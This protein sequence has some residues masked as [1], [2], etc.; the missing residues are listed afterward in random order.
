MGDG[1][2]FGAAGRPPETATRPRLLLRATEAIADSVDFGD[3]LDQ[4]A[5]LAVTEIADIC[6]IDAIHD[7]RIVRLAAVHRDPAHQSLVDELLDKYPPV[8]GGPHPVARV[9]E[10]QSVEWLP[11]MN[12]DFLRAT[13]QDERHL[14]LV[15]S[16]RFSSFVS[17]P[18]ARFDDTLGALTV[19]RS[20][21]QPPF[22]EHDVDLLTD[23]ARLA[24]VHLGN[25]LLHEQRDAADE[26]LRATVERLGRLH[27]LTDLALAALSPDAFIDEVMRRLR[28]VLGANTVRILLATPDGRE[29]I[30]AGALGLGDM[31]EWRDE[32]PVGEG[33]AGTIAATR[34]PL[35]V[36]PKL[37]PFDFLSPAL[38]NLELVAG[39]PLLVRD[40]LIGVIHVGSR[41]PRGFDDDDLRLLELA[42][43]RIAIAIDQNQRLEEER[44]KTLLLQETLLP[45]VLPEVPGCEIAF[46]YWP[47]DH[48][49]AVGGDFY[50]VFA[51]GENRFGVLIGDVAG[52]GIAAAAFTGLARHT[53]RTAARHTRTIVEPL[54]WLH[55]A[56]LDSAGGEYCTALYGSLI[57]HPH[58]VT[59]DFALGGHPRA[60]LIGRDGR[61]D[62]T[63]VPGTALGLIPDVHFTVTSL[64][65]E[66]GDL[67]ILYTDGITDTHEHPLSDDELRAVI[68]PAVMP[69]A[70]A[71][72]DRIEQSLRALRSRQDDDIA[73]IAIRVLERACD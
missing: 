35:V 14:E 36:A 9:L 46:R 68:G 47:A 69:D 16:L 5:R 58:G 6:L 49:L 64:L 4:L 43:E 39:V 37:Q 28:R 1:T 70:E 72:L 27:E 12:A 65:L 31:S 48:S 15:T 33:F 38:H 62:H 42:A 45:A 22:D 23:L 3:A 11:D 20:D 53:V 2:S 44:H 29:L 50:D 8:A 19:I 66:P 59:I 18:I 60:L 13:T 67:M 26:A 21:D 10:N 71:T 73:I 25:S 40:R 55:E 56:M 32:L 30:G 51:I 57:P 52:K 63:G 54:Q 7:G 17:V 34:A 24:A 41:E 61:I